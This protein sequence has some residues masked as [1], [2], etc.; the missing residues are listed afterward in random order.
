[1]QIAA[2]EEKIPLDELYHICHIARD[3]MQG[4][5][6]VGRVIARPFV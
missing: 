5:H 1:M 2:H 4:E 6:G 3:M